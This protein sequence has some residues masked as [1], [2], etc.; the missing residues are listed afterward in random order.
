MFNEIVIKARVTVDNFVN[1]QRGVTAI[2]YAIIGV[3]VSAL[4]LAVFATDG[5]GLQAAIS[6]AIGTIATN[7]TSAN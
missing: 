3:A 6:G 5:A 4:V 2:E 7:I 1:D